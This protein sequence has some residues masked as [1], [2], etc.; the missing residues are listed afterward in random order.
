MRIHFFQHVPFETPGTIAD[1]AQSRGHGVSG[2]RSFAGEAPPDVDEYDCLVVMGGP[3]SVHD[4]A[5]YPWLT[6][7]KRAVELSMERGKAVVGICLGAQLIA[8]VL[9]ANVHRHLTREIGWFPVTLTPDAASHPLTSDLPDTFTALHWH[10]D[11]YDLP[12]GAVHLAGSRACENQMF[13]YD[14]PVLGIQFHVEMTAR[15][16]VDLIDNCRDEI[17]ED[18]HVQSAADIARGNTH[19]QGGHAVLDCL[20]DRL[21]EKIQSQSR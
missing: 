8:H 5:V 7:E 18:E 9:G 6:N 19:L 14:G 3:M 12:D 2:T 1:W 13:A 11:T 15:G 10:G 17:V 20:L 16:V 4:D 21:A